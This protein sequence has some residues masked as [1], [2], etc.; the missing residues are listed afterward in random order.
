[1]TN[2]N[3][4]IHTIDHTYYN[5]NT[6]L[7]SVEH[8]QSHTLFER[9]GTSTETTRRYWRSIEDNTHQVIDDQETNDITYD[10]EYEIVD[11]FKD[12]YFMVKNGLVNESNGLDWIKDIKPK[13]FEVF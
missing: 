1:M 9:W 6:I 7:W 3:S 13:G 2:K 5:Q 11:S 4:F 10:G 12:F 8:I